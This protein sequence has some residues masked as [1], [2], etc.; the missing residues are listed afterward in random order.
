MPERM[1]AAVS[2]VATASKEYTLAF[3]YV[4][5]AIAGASGGCLVASHRLLNGRNLTALVFAA[6]G[7][8]GLVLGLTGVI[9]ISVFTSIQLTLETTFLLGLIFGVTG[10]ASLAGMNLSARFLMK[11]LGLEVDVSIKRIRNDRYRSDRDG[12]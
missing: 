3:L 6:Y 8:A 4:V 5:A 11:R 7:F 9:V 10:S 1:I 12:E 2:S